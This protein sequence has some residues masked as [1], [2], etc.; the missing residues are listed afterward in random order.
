MQE[1]IEMI[2]YEYPIPKKNGKLLLLVVS[3]RFSRFLQTKLIRFSL[4]NSY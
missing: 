1:D 2:L 3:Y 4:C